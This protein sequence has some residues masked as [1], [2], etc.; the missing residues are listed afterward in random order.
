MNTFGVKI[1]YFFN[2]G[3]TI[4]TQKY[5]L[6]FDFYLEQART[7][8]SGTGGNMIEERLLHTEKE[9]LV[10]VSHSHADHFNPAIFQWQKQRKDINYILSSDIRIPGHAVTNK[11]AVKMIA[12]YGEQVLGEV[13]IKAYGS[14]DEGVS[15]LVKADGLTIFHAGDLN[16]WYWW[17]DSEEER[18]DAEDRF[19]KE[20]AKI[21]GEE[22]DLA[23]FPVDPRLEHNFAAG[24]KYF[25]EELWPKAFIPMHFG[26][27]YEIIDYFSEKVKHLKTRVIKINSSP[28]RFFL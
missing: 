15:F 1:T 11:Y 19:K 7:E 27:D 25:I 24:G 16:W 6:I 5:C 14:T 3:F 13:K 10:F 21:K 9:V 2:S 12:P 22:I 23:F 8:T 17:D 18:R 4:E 20:I 26:E 28:Q